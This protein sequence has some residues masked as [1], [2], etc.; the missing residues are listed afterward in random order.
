MLDKTIWKLI[1]HAI[2]LNKTENLLYLFHSPLRKY[3]EKISRMIFL[4]L[5]IWLIY[6]NFSL[7]QHNFGFLQNRIV[8]AEKNCKRKNRIIKWKC[9][10]K[11]VGNVKYIGRNATTASHDIQ[12]DQSSVLIIILLVV[13]QSLWLYLQLKSIPYQLLFSL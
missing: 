3:N 12:K 10:M 2:D 9:A 8:K 11:W 1:E 7:N 13:F 5:Q 4:C 6:W